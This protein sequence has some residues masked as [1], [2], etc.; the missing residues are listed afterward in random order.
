MKLSYKEFCKI[1]V[2][3]KWKIILIL[4]CIFL[5]V[6]GRGRG[7]TQHYPTKISNSR[8]LIPRLACLLLNSNPR[9]SIRLAI[10]FYQCAFNFTIQNTL[11]SGSKGDWHG[12]KSAYSK[13][14][15]RRRCS[16][17]LRR[18][19]PKLVTC[20]VYRWP[21]SINSIHMYMHIWIDLH[22]DHF[23]YSFNNL[24]IEENQT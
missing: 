13:Y 21:M 22:F 16:T 4:P 14:R 6:K 11:K 12:N 19:Q 1:P 8:V 3:C 15:R 9:Q 18:A 7:L 23:N 2:K 5:I 10:Q 17:S 24:L 20:T